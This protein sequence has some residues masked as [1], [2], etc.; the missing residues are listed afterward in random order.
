MQGQKPS[1]GLSLSDFGSDGDPALALEIDRVHC[2]LVRDV[3]S[4][5]SEEPV[6]ESGLPVVDVS[7]HRHVPQPA[8]VQRCRRRRGG[9][10]GGG[11]TAAQERGSR[12][13][14]RPRR[15]RLGVPRGGGCRQS[16]PAG[17]PKAAQQRTRHFPSESSPS[18][19]TAQ[20]EA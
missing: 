19:A 15:R 13:N 18:S 20:A 17:R 5:L 6:H 8:G 12:G 10:G 9:G 4:T 3:G 14:H 16:P 2:P 11:K 1:S 7:N